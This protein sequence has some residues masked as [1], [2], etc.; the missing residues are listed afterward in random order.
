MIHIPV[1]VKKSTLLVLSEHAAEMTSTAVSINRTEAIVVLDAEVVMTILQQAQPG[2]ERIDDVIM[3][4][5]L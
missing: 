1:V 4:R 2:D 5:A 3:R